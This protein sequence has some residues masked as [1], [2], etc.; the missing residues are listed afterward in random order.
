MLDAG[1]SYKT[2]YCIPLWLRD[3]QIK[4]NCAT[5]GIGRLTPA[6]ADQYKDETIAIVGFGPSLRDTWEEIRNFN[7][8]MTCS[9]AHKFLIERSITPSWHVEV[10]PR[11]HKIELL[12]TPNSSTIYLPASTCH[13]AYM[14]HLL[15]HD[16][17]IRMWHV[18]DSGPDAYRVLPRGEWYIL[19]GSN[20]GMRAM[21]LARFLGFRKMVVFGMDGNRRETGHAAPHP[22]QDQSGHSLLTYDGV[23]YKTTTGM[24]E[25]A[26]QTFHELDMMPD[27]EA[28]FRGEGLVQ[29]MA[30]NYVR[31]P[32]DPKK[33]YL[34]AVEKPALYSSE[35]RDLCA[36]LHRDNLAFGVG[37]GRHAKVVMA[38]AAK[39]KTTS[40]LD[41]GCG[42]G[43]LG[44]A[45]PWPIWEYDPAIPGKDEAP[46]PADL[47]VCLDVLEHIEPDRL[48]FVL[49][50][51][52]RVTK[53]AGFFIIPMGPS[54]KTLADGRN[55]HLI[56]EGRDWWELQLRRHFSVVKIT[57]SRSLLSVLVTP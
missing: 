34:I 32:K 13:P 49:D 6:A 7:F 47:V 20:V 51:L 16:A 40:V 44:R 18:F 52:R 3:E 9:G 39:L 50:D 1:V 22:L 48:T 4:L 37:A 2:E 11:E 43:Y 28:E 12:G 14:A 56:Q 17:R 53:K 24:L 57:E 15:K 19:G 29:H 31:K 27:V 8:V 26:K 30:K 36:R 5:D 41:Y 21:A 42:K 25:S 54:T 55:A 46:R 33:E 10:D 23:E 35:Y 38:I 45:L